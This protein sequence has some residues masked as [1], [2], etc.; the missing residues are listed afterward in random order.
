[1]SPV[2]APP[3][4]RAPRPA[5]SR[6]ALRAL[7]GALALSGAAL[8]AAQCGSTRS[9]VDASAG[10]RAW[11]VVY[12]VL[13]HPRCVNCHPAGESPLVGELME[14][15]PQNV[16][17]GPDGK[18]LFA[19]RC[20]TCHQ[21]RNTDGPHMPPGAPHWQLPAPEMPL[22]FEGRSSA[23]LCRQLAD[24]ALNGDRTPDEVARHLA[25]DPLVSWGWDPGEGRAPVPVPREELVAAARAWVES[26]CDCP[27]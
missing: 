27:E 24:R 19:M 5:R 12:S 20:A 8:L 1:M 13:Q 2:P 9:A 4:P 22:V 6:R 15:H 26:G 3:S 17:R 21:P 14:P 16:R 10:A 23:E 18:G 7:A 11:G 25:E